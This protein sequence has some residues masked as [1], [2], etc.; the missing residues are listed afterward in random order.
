MDRAI[1][2]RIR[3]NKILTRESNAICRKGQIR[4]S[5]TVDVNNS[6]VCVSGLLEYPLLVLAIFDIDPFI[7]ILPNPITGVRAKADFIG[8]AS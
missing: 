4:N 8:A 6:R 7:N 1:W 5:Q 3:P 2:F